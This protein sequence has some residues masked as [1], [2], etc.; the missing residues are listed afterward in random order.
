VKIKRLR[1]FDF[2][3]TL[4]K[5]R[6]FVY[7]KNGNKTKKLT[8]GE[9]AIY[10]EKPGDEFDYSDFEFVKNPKE[11]K[12]MTKVL[13]AILSKSGGSINILTARSNYK[14]IRK[15]LKDINIDISR[16][17]VIALASNDPADKVN[18]IKNKIENESYNDIFFVDD[19]LKNI[20]A[21]KEMLSKTKVKWR[22]QHVKY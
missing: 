9:Y 15:Y 3:D 7:V 1:I 21:A 10:E 18:W 19:S 2:D 16:I 17:Y 11:I 5:T 6:S 4:V 20:N 22:V 13:K 14:P 8:P 12:Q